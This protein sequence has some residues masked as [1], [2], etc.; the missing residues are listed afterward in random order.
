MKNLNETERLKFSFFC[1]V[2]YFQGHF[3]LFDSLMSQ[4]LREGY[5]SHRRPAF[6]LRRHV[7]DSLRQCQ[8]KR[9][10]TTTTKNACLKPKIWDCACA[11]E[12]PQTEKTLGYFARVPAQLSPTTG[13][14]CPTNKNSRYQNDSIL[15]L[16]LSN[17]SISFK[18]L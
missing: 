16:I 1:G 10:K 2:Q 14:P 5:L 7:V 12:E 15:N 8:T 4:H 9:K 18:R 13:K 11:F 6:A 3:S 17:I